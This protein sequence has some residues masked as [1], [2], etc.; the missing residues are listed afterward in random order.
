[1]LKNKGVYSEV[2]VTSEYS[3]NKMLEAIMIRKRKAHSLP[4]EFLVVMT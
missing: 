4:C 3:R 2:G 1:M